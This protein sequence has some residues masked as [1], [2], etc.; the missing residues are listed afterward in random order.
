MLDRKFIRDNPEVVRDAIAKK[1]VDLDLDR[2]L[3]LDGESRALTTKVDALQGQRKSIAKDFRDLDDK[4]RAEHQE[5]SQAL[6]AELAAA[7]L[8][9]AEVDDRLRDLLLMTPGIP[10]E[11]APIGAGEAENKF[12][13][14]WGEPRSFDF[15]PRSHIDILE[16]RGWVD[17][18][19]ARNASGERS[20]VLMRDAVL[21]ERALHSFALD[22]L[23]DAGY[24]LASV[25]SL[26]RERA[27]VGSGMFPKGR[28][29]TYELVG[30]QD[31]LAGTGEVALVGMHADEILDHTSLPLAYA[32]WSP[33]FRSEIGSAGRDVRGLIRVHQFQKVE[34]FVICE[35]DDGTSAQ[36][37]A[38]LVETAEQLLRL[39][40][41]PYE[42]VE[43]STGDMGLGKFRMNDINTWFPSLGMYRETHSASTLHEWQARRA[44]I[45][46]RDAQGKVRF[47]H[48]LNN[49][50]V[51]TPRLLAAFIENHQDEDGRVAIPDPL[52]RYL[53]GR[54]VL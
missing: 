30:E 29:E 24:L 53:G 8:E 26:V 14:A 40:Q 10:W 18:E 25:P 28:E 13:G 32:A 47:A 27:L 35:A 44:N 20:Y 12:I 33:C 21:L 45:R 38:R 6:S 43:C 9:L 11:G 2:L 48:T 16:N 7:K 23:V 52:R 1:N 22:L 3:E 39:L 19:R 50:A 17:F 49:T 15:E 34:Q 37:H 5:R 41:L 31:F 54:T 4:Q 46:Y 42:I 36:W 51:A